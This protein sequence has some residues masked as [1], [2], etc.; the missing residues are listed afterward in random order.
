MRPSKNKNRRT[1]AKRED[2]RSQKSAGAREAYASTVARVALQAV[3]EIAARKQGP[4]QSRRVVNY[5]RGNQFPP[6]AAGDPPGDATLEAYGLFWSA[7]ASWVGTLLEG[8]SEGGYLDI[9]LEVGRGLSVT[10]LGECLLAGEES[11]DPSVLPHRPVLGSHPEIEKRLRDLRS[12]LAAEKG[13]PPYGIF[14]NETLA[15]LAEHRPQNLGEL[16]STPG[17]GERRLEEFGRRIL[18]VLRRR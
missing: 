14:S 12:R 6:S 8:L 3:R 1:K 17:L 13:R 18:A 2:R 4:V 5:L 15:H 16:A 9:G 7:S 11:A 10:P